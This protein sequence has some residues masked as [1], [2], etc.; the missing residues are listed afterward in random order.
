MTTRKRALGDRGKVVW[1]QGTLPDVSTANQNL[2]IY[3]P[4]TG[5]VTECHFVL[6]DAIGTGDSTLTITNGGTAWS[7]GTV[8]VT[9]SGGDTG[10]V[11]SQTS[12]EENVTAGSYIS[13]ASD[14]AST[15]TVPIHCTFKL[16]VRDG[17]VK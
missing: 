2:A 17:A 14:G 13:V 1:L 7:G 15:G 8:T 6:G 5:V 11:D 4:E 10:D 3:V 12:L 9:Q 16:V